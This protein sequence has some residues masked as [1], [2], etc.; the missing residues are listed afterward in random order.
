VSF[1]AG[2]KSWIQNQLFEYSRVVSVTPMSQRLIPWRAPRSRPLYL[3]SGDGLSAVEP[4][5]SSTRRHRRRRFF[6]VQATSHA[7]CCL[8]TPY[9]FAIATQCAVIPPFYCFASRTRASL[10]TSS[11]R[12]TVCAIRVPAICADPTAHCSVYIRRPS[13]FRC[14]TRAVAT[15]VVYALL[16]CKSVR[17][18][19]KTL[20]LFSANL[21]IVIV[22][23]PV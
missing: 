12:T 15:H 21:V 7:K 9:A 19:A 5:A 23:S 6:A 13:D 11:S 10:L 8:A 2:R 4:P 1:N 22:S 20:I 14:A 3:R 16:F 17:R 18:R